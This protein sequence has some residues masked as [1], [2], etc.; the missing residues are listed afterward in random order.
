MIGIGRIDGRIKHCTT[1]TR[2]YKSPLII[3]AIDIDSMARLI[4]VIAWAITTA[5]QNYSC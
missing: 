5:D 4:I 1:T 2:A 3:S